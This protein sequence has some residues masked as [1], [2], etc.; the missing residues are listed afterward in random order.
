MFSQNKRRSM[1]PSQISN[2]RLPRAELDGVKSKDQDVISVITVDR[3]KKFNDIQGTV[4]GNAMDEIAAKEI[5]E[6]AEG[7]L[8]PAQ[9]EEGCGQMGQDQEDGDLR[10]EERDE[11]M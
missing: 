4:A 7:E 5:A 2:A 10:E 6:Y 8:E 9:G 1:A 3:L 11:M